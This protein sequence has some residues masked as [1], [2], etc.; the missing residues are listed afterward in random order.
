MYT[1]LAKRV[2]HILFNATVCGRKRKGCLTQTQEW[3]FASSELNKLIGS[4]FL[5]L[6]GGRKLSMEQRNRYRRHY[7]GNTL[8]NE[9][10]RPESQNGWLYK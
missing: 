10:R 8:K 5:Q 4:I 3:A 7:K 1:L 9:R 2:A 6:A